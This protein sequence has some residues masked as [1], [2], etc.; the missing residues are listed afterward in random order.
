MGKHISLILLFTSVER[1]I[2]KQSL[3]H[4]MVMSACIRTCSMKRDVFACKVKNLHSSNPI[5]RK[6]VN[7]PPSQRTKSWLCT[8]I[9]TETWGMAFLKNSDFF[10]FFNHHTPE[11]RSILTF[12]D[13]RIDGHILYC[14]CSQA[15]L[16][17]LTCP[18]WVFSCPQLADSVFIFYRTDP[19]RNQTKGTR[20]AQ[21]LSNSSRPFPT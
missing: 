8:T 20:Q 15:V 1:W 3:N 10:F 4:L 14:K 17:R 13:I 19:L 5:G 7:I 12:V 18:R 16:L 21:F 6:V 9:S 11:A 2:L